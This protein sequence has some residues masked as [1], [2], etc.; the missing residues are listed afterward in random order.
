MITSIG[1][2]LQSMARV[3]FKPS[4]STGRNAG[5]EG[6][7]FVATAE[8][9]LL[10]VLDS[11]GESSLF[12]TAGKLTPVLPGLE[13]EGIGNVGVPVSAA[14]AKRIIQQ[15]AQAPYG[16][17]EET[18]VD[19]SVRRVWQLEPRQFSLKNAAWEPFIAGIVEA[20]RTEFAIPQKVELQLYKL[21]VYEKGSFFAP[22]R[23]S[24]KAP[25]MF[26]TLVVCLPSKHEGGTLI[27][28]HDGQTQQID[29]GG[30]E[31]Q[32][33]VQYAAFYADCQHEVLP[34]ASGYRICLI[35]NLAI[36]RKKQPSPP[37]SS[38]AVQAAAELLPQLFQDESR[39]KLAIPLKHQYT[40]AAL[41]PGELKGADRARVDVLVR[42]AQQVNYQ[43]FLALMTHHQS[44]AVDYNTMDYDPYRSR[45]RYYDDYEDEEDEDDDL[46]ASDDSG[47]EFEE[48]FE[49]S[50]SLDHWLDPQGR[51]QPFGALSLDE[52][53]IVS[54]VAP[55]DRPYRQEIQR[56]H[57][58]RRGLDG[59]LVSPSGRGDLAARP[60]LQHPGG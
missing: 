46:D 37:T 25:G 33:Q 10:K 32:F 2:P 12:C 16:R 58:Q 57:R 34:V 4:G 35:Y 6:V 49:E 26:A 7:T 39:D 52:S 48:V 60:V 51:P 9:E 42:A 11:L 19:T 54:D 30:S 45:R 28:T 18:I 38:G 31:A 29:F 22:H 5:E 21:L 15:A 47:A 24:E 13:V 14:D 1:A 41:A 20:V 50:M 8:N 55:E 53:E 56:S 27:V 36:G 3:Q 17:G 43:A 44:G 59:P 23:D 40:Q